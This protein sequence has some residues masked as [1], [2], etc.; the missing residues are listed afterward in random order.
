[1]PPLRHAHALRDRCPRA[2]SPDSRSRS[3]RCTRSGVTSSLLV[4]SYSSRSRS[5]ARGRLFAGHAEGVAAALDAYVQPR[6]EQAQVLIERPAQIRQACVVGRDE[7]EFPQDRAMRPPRA[8]AARRRG[9]AGSAGSASPRRPRRLWAS[10]S[11][12][13]TSCEATDEL[14][15]SGKIDPAVVGGAAGELACVLLRGALDEH[16]LHACRP[17]PR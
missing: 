13:V 6:F 17:C 14:G 7:I 5:S 9:A 8:S 12:T 15:R 16:A 4:S 11:V 1:M 2:A 3:A 10:A